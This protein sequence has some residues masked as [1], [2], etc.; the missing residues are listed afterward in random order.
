[1]CGAHA[2]DTGC[3]TRIDGKETNKTLGSDLVTGREALCELM[4]FKP[5]GM[6]R[7]CRAFPRHFFSRCLQNGVRGFYS[8][9]DQ[10]FSSSSGWAQE[11]TF[12]IRMNVSQHK[13]VSSF[14]F[15]WRCALSSTVSQSP[16]SPVEQGL[17]ISSTDSFFHGVMTQS[18]EMT[19]RLQSWNKRRRNDD[20]RR[21]RGRKTSEKETAKHWKKR[22][23]SSKTQRRHRTHKLGYKQCLKEIGQKNR[24]LRAVIAKEHDRSNGVDDEAVEWH[25]TTICQCSAP[26][27]EYDNQKMKEYAEDKYSKMIRPSPLCKRGWPGWKIQITE[28]AR[29]KRTLRDFTRHKK[30]RT[31]EGQ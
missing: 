6:Q 11:R 15:L 24:T 28:E 19:L 12:W 31:G 7:L 10:A 16:I 4:S 14:F 27:N 13:L 22:K 23:R 2:L 8:I 26:R 17:C 25:D 21:N 3:Q 5:F 9:V 29:W 18:L 1:M 30:S 20:L